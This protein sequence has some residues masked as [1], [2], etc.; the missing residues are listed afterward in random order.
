[1]TQ[2]FPS[3]SS[4]EFAAAV[5]D[6]VA[7]VHHYANR[8]PFLDTHLSWFAAILSHTHKLSSSPPY[9]A[10]PIADPSFVSARFRLSSDSLRFYNTAQ[11]EWETI[12]DFVSYEKRLLSRV[13]SFP[14]GDLLYKIQ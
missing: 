8:F 11:S 5:S 12:I 9:N 14:S 6:T 1:M 2:S 10:I 3:S 7:F 13:F 4:P